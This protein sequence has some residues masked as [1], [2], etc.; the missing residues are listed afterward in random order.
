MNLAELKNHERRL[1]REHAKL[2]S[3]AE[4]VR[5]E[6]SIMRQALHD[7]MLEAGGGSRGWSRYE[8]EVYDQVRDTPSKTI[9]TDDKLV[10]SFLRRIRGLETFEG[11]TTGKTTGFTNLPKYLNVALSKFNDFDLR[12][13]SSKSRTGVEDLVQRVHPPFVQGVTTNRAYFAWVPR[14][15]LREYSDK[16]LIKK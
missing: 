3:D 10:K 6:L 7:A 13:V 15:V 14:S 4:F 12:L 1:T 11:M 8:L 9:R 2:M 16:H 5:D